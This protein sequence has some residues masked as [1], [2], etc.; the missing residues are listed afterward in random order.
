MTTGDAL[1]VVGSLEIVCT[2]F[3]LMFT[4]GDR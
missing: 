2:F 4:A 1:A 3:Y